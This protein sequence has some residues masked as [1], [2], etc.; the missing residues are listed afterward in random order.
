MIISVEEKM[1]TVNSV[2]Y[3]DLEPQIKGILIKN[4]KKKTML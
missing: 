4:A 3:N 1:F 2:Q